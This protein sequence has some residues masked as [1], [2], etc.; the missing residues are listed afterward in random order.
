VN[1]DS[2]DSENLACQP[3]PIQPFNGDSHS[4]RGT[5]AF[6]GRAPAIILAS[7]VLATAGAAS[8]WWLRSDGEAIAREQTAKSDLARL[9]ALVVMDSTRKHVASVNLSTLKSPEALDQAISLLPAFTRLSSLNGDGAMFRD[10]HASIVGQLASLEDLVLSHTRVTDSALE[11]LQRLSKLKTIHLADTGVTNAS[12]PALGRLRALTIVDLSGTRV[13]GNFEPL[14]N[15]TNLNWLVLGRL[16][17]DA[18]AIV[19]IGDCP[20]LSR[21]TLKGS[22]CSPEALQ[23]LAEKRPNLAID[24]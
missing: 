9:G 16:S 14:Q 21:L 8:A 18:A 19:A 2:K 11:S 7:F 10:E 24:Q 12:L 23:K 22:T 3:L 20:N 13:T 5:T 17:L 4:S 6:S 1:R 15:L